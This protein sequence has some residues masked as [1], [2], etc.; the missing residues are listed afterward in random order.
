MPCAPAPR[1]NPLA[2]DEEVCWPISEQ[3]TR[4]KDGCVKS[5]FTVGLAARSAV[6]WGLVEDFR[7]ILATPE[8]QSILTGQWLAQFHSLQDA[9]IEIANWSAEDRNLIPFTEWVLHE[10]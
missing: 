9:V 3:I 2:V 1:F 10:A 4:F 7:K 5:G 6:N 8:Q